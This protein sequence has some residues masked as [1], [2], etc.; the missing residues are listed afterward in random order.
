MLT[1]FCFF[2]LIIDQTARAVM[3]GRGAFN[4]SE[5]VAV[6]D[7]KQHIKQQPDDSGE[8]KTVTCSEYSIRVSLLFF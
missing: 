8:V 1:I 4:M 7:N 2:D 5:Q 3:R 6:L